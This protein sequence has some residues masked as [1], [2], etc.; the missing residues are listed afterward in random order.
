[1]AI[2]I[3][4]AITLP[5][6]NRSAAGSKTHQV[7]LDDIQRR[8]LG[9]PTVP[10][11]WILDDD[12]ETGKS[13]V[14]PDQRDASKQSIPRHAYK[15]LSVSKTGEPEYELDEY[16]SGHEFMTSEGTHGY[17][18][19]QVLFRFEKYFKGIDPW[20]CNVIQSTGNRSVSLSEVDAILKQWGLDRLR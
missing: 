6:C 13:W 5:S 19:I 1:M 2:F 9:L 17:E 4:F 14:N 8:T 12:D 11:N 16:F 18:H 15:Q 3:A 7:A 10:A 20:E